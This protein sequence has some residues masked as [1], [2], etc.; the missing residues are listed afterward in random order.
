MTDEEVEKTGTLVFGQVLS[1][2]LHVWTS[3]KKLQRVAESLEI[4]KESEERERERGLSKICT[5]ER[6]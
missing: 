4:I 3:L 2:C 6:K 1:R 5:R